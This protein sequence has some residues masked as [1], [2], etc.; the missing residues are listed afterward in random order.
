M[1]RKRVTE[2]LP[3]LLPLRRWQRKRWYYRRMARDGNRYAGTVG[4]G[5]LPVELFRSA[6]PMINADTG[7]DIRYQENK[8]FNLKLAA[9]RLDGL[10]IRPG[11]VFSFWDRVR[12][13]DR[14][15][16]YRE[17]LAEV[18]GRLTTQYGGGLCMLSNLL[19]WLILHTPMTVVERWGHDV[20]DFP[21]PD[22][23]AV[24][25]T[26]ATVAEGWLDLKARNDTGMVFQVRIGFEDGNITG[27]VLADR[28]EGLR[29]GVIAR[30]L[31]Y[32]RREDGIYETVTVCRTIRRASDGQQ[33]EERPL[34]RNR[35]RIGYALPEWTEI[36]EGRE[37]T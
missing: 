25:G 7:F 18:N 37:E 9:R 20:K 21:E 15:T 26:D 32:T 16:P 13:A 33:T 24:S 8:V 35:C 11:E 17:G 12:Y 14:D 27:R 2:V 34:Y 3:F 30:N 29:Y 4:E 28:D 22:S 1:R 10:L 19:F 5:E 31:R 23:D 36:T 6:C